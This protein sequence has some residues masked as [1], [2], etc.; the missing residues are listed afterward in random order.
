MTIV[1]NGSDS[2]GGRAAGCEDV[3][4]RREEVDK[5]LRGG[6]GTGENEIEQTMI[7]ECLIRSLIF[8]FDQCLPLHSTVTYN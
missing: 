7:F 1:D 5:G 6:P 2:P 8:P 4:Q 3:K